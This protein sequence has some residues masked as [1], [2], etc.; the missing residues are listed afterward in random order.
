M[1]TIHAKPKPL[2]QTTP[3]SA[4]PA[5]P[6]A[7]R[8]CEQILLGATEIFDREGFGHASVDLIAEAANVSK[9]TLYKYFAT[10]EELFQAVVIRQC[11]AHRAV[12]CELGNDDGDIEE[13]LV[14]MAIK[15]G[16]VFSSR[17][18]LDL[19]R[20]TVA[21]IGRFPELAETFFKAG[22]QAGV[23]YIGLVLKRFCETGELAIDDID[24]AAKQFK[25]LAKVNIFH[26]A[27][28]GVDDTFTEQERDHHARV[29]VATFLKIYGTKASPDS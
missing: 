29:A 15:L 7:Q 10:K 19:F 8:K 21:E 23:H 18:M 28:F 20:L 16:R 11:E 1:T 12:L 5:T 2:V 22:P 13:V 9:A 24:L 3:S 27:I 17:V 6:R 25:E 14:N 26:R 4:A